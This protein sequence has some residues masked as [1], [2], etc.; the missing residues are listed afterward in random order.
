MPSTSTST[1]SSDYPDVPTEE[2]VYTA[3]HFLDLDRA[4][5]KLAPSRYHRPMDVDDDDDVPTPQ[6]PRDLSFEMRLD[7]LHFDSLSFDPEEFDISMDRNI[8]R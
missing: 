8:L 7:S 4:N 5:Q 3:V 6:H 1:V 2:G